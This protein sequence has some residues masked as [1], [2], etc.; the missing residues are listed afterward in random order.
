MIKTNDTYLIRKTKYFPD[1]SDDKWSDWHWQV[2]NR[3]TSVEALKKFI[4]QSEQ[5]Q[6]DIR[7]SFP[8]SGWR[9]LLI[10]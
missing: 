10:I 2:K 3:I 9:L 8:N 4:P 7:M 5:E 1:V 6:D